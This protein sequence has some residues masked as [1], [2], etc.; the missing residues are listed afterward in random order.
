MSRIYIASRYSRKPE[1]LKYIS[2]LESAGH[3]VQADWL[4][5]NH[6]HTPSIDCAEID[7]TDVSACDIFL[8]F[9]EEPR[10][11]N[12]RGGRHVEFGMALAL[13]KRLIIVGPEENIFHSLPQVERVDTFRE[14]KYLIGVS[15]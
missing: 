4:Q 6:D 5:S 9:T 7:I 12:S 13:K 10:T 3:T 14:L 2:V 8:T 15:S 1:M 11:T